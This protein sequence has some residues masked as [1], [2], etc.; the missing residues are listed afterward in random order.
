MKVILMHGKDTSPEEKWYPWF[1]EELNRSGIEVH[2]PD[3]PSPNEP[4]M[5]EWLEMLNN[6]SPDE[7]TMLVGHSRGG[8]AIMRYLEKLPQDKRVKKVILVASNSGSAKFMANPT[9]SNHGFYT[10]GGF[11]FDEIKTHCNDF[12]VYHSKDDPWVPF[13]HGKENAEGL[14]AKFLIFEDKKHFGKNDGIVPGLIDEVL[15]HK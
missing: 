5:K 11:N 3:L 4:I 15:K 9:E 6:L 12:V 10:E 14:D 8:V 13:E 7:E 2:I 1:K